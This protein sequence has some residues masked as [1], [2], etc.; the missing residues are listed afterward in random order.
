MNHGLWIVYS[1]VNQ[2]YLLMWHD[3]VLGVFNTRAEAELEMSD[4]LRPVAELT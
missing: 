2:A 4:L 3:S 1:P